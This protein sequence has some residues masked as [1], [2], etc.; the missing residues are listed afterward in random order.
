VHLSAEAKLLLQSQVLE[1]VEQAVMVVDLTGRIVFW[2]RFAE[3]LSGW[4]AEE[5]QGRSID[6]VFGTSLLMEAVHTNL[7]QI[8]DIATD[9]APASGAYW[10]GEF[11]IQRRR[12]CKLFGAP[13]S[14]AHV[15]LSSNR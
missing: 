8:L 5:A 10:S 9:L 3:T 14:F 13:Q 12:W 2:N 4:S 6:E 7:A 1:V 15:R 11:L